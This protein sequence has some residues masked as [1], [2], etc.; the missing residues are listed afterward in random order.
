M[1]V[2]LQRLLGVK[3]HAVA[4]TGFFDDAT[5]DAARALEAGDQHPARRA[6]RPGDVAAARAPRSAAATVARRCC[7]AEELL[8]LGR[9]RITPDDRFTNGTQDLVLAFQRRHGLPVDGIVDID[10]WRVL[11][12][13][14]SGART[15]RSPPARHDHADVRRRPP[16]AAA[17]SV[18]P[19]TTPIS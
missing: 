13:L 5:E 3:D 11:L 2:A 12:A 16:R 9:V 6:R 14:A 18:A 4:V 7:A 8:Q 15:R 10:T 1:V 17:T 19:S